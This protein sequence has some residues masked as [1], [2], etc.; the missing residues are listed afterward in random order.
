VVGSRVL[1]RDLLDK[2]NNRAPQF[3]VFDKAFTK[4]KPSDVARKSV[5]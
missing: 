1:R 4:D 5:T 3:W 2:P